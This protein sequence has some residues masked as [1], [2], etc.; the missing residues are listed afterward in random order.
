MPT[1]RIETCCPPVSSYKA[2][3]D[4]RATVPD[5]ECPTPTVTIFPA[6]GTYVIMP[7]FVVLTCNVAGAVIYYTTDGTEP[8]VESTVYSAPFEVSSHYTMVKARAKLAGCD[9]GPIST[10]TYPVLE[11]SNWAFAYLC[12]TGDKVGAFD[13]FAANGEANDYQF[14]LVFTIDADT[15]ILD[16]TILQTDVTGYWNSGQS[17]STKEYIYP[18]ADPTIPFH[19]YPLV[20]I[21]EVGPTQLFTSYQTTLGVIAADTYEWR[22]WG[23]PFAALNGFFLARITLGDGTVIKRMIEATCTPP[24]PPC[25]T[26]AALTLA[27]SC[28]PAISYTA[29]P[30]EICRIWRRSVCDEGGEGF[31]VLVEERA[32][33]LFTTDDVD[34]QYCC[35]YDYYIEEFCGDAWVASA[36]SS[37]TVPCECEIGLSAPTVLCLGESAI[38]SYTGSNCVGEISWGTGGEG[39]GFTGLGAL[40][41]DLTVT[42]EVT[43]TYTFKGTS[44]ECGDF[45]EAVTIE[46]VVCGECDEYPEFFTVIGFGEWRAGCSGAEC[47]FGSEPAA[48]WDGVLTRVSPGGCTWAMA[49]WTG[50]ME[51]PHEG[52]QCSNLTEDEFF[53]IIEAVLVKEP[54]RWRL[55]LRLGAFLYTWVGLS[56]GGDPEGEYLYE[57][58][59]CT[60]LLSVTVTI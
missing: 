40:S 3:A 25:P 26:P 22:L 55:T 17:W 48:L 8:T 4:A 33:G 42:P 36:V 37:I 9:I 20:V 45:Y 23:Q 53:S 12:A 50:T 14:V 39:G 15:E 18:F 59:T 29:T 32:A 30:T 10:A 57:S 24:P 2:D 13:E 31:W 38:I 46:V 51:G 34:V 56:D 21:D 52:T 5:G 1:C 60:E 19:T 35:T 7:T 58:G 54:T 11:G 28:F 16:I 47:N 41:G 43:T 6:D 44:V 27:A 49:A